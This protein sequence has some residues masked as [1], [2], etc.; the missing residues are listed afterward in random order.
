MKKLLMIFAM[1]M[2]LMLPVFATITA[3]MTAES[4]YKGRAYT[5]S[6]QTDSI[7]NDTSRV[8][9]LEKYLDYKTESDTN[10][11]ELPYGY[12]IVSATGGVKVTIKLQGSFDGV[13]WI[14]AKTIGTDIT[15]ETATN[16]VIDIGLERFPYYR[17][18]VD[19]V[20]TNSPDTN[21]EFWLFP[22]W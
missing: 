3:D 14:D 15:N 13:T 18:V 8:W 9:S 16:G 22:Y 2:L 12:K 17:I 21:V 20:E 10:K 5:F 19:G 6:T 11:L 4:F 1:V 7:E